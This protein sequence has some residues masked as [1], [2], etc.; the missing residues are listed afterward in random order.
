MAT[1]LRLAG[2]FPAVA[3]AT[4]PVVLLRR[5]D[6]PGGE[7]VEIAHALRSRLNQREAA[8][9]GG[10]FVAGDA[11][12]HLPVVE[13]DHAPQP[14]DVIVDG[15]GARWTVLEAQLVALR[16]RWRCVARNL[17]LRYGLDDTVTI[18]AADCAKQP[19][20]AAEPTWSVWRTGV[21]ARIEPAEV[22]PRLAGGAR[23]AA[24][25]CRML[26]EQQLWLDHR[27]RIRAADGALY[28]VVRT[29]AARLGEPATIDLE[30][31]A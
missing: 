26:V 11:V 8:D 12:W 16:T 27:H 31:E 1:L 7:G 25:R 24:V 18:L 13:F 20:G 22:V 17:A 2:D 23:R 29:S 9:S 10:R 15:D 19:G 6:Q 3:D 28:R 4:Q 30:R 21:R 14:G 5:G